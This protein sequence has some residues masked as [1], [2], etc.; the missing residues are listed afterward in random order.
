MSRV[1]RSVAGVALI[2]MVLLM[3]GAFAFPQPAQAC[4]CG[5]SCCGFWFQSIQSC[6]TYIE[7]C[8]CIH[9][10]VCGGGGPGG[11]KDPTP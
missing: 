6:A 4:P 7:D 8:S 2:F 5:E 9:I 1:R 11:P 3:V 10:Q